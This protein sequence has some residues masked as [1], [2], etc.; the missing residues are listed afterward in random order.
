M[1]Q[2]K[3]F[4]TRY[5][6][7]I[8]INYGPKF[9]IKIFLFIRTFNKFRKTIN[10]KKNF[11]LFSKKNLNDINKFEF[12]ITSQNNEDGIIEYIFSKIP[13][14]KI[15]CEIGFGYYEFNSLNLIQ[16]GWSGKLVDGSKIECLAL[17]SNLSFFFPN[18]E[19]EIFNKK[20]TK[21][22]INSLIFQG[23]KNQIIDFFSIDIDGND[24]WVLKNLDLELINVIC[25]EYNHWFG[26]EKKTMNYIEDF[27]FLD[28]GIFGASLTAITDL[29]NKKDFSLIGVESSGT[30]AFFVKN[31]Y[32]KYFK[33]LTPDESFK[34]VGR[35]YSKEK[36]NLIFRNIKES[37]IL[38]NI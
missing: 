26:M 9:L 20:V 36:K 11:T 6:Q 32:I 5:I 18:A 34:S 23:I 27:N 2:S 28:D 15:F 25:C 38:E 37:N 13:N 31:K 30:N 22:N 24:Y 16:K 33:T 29:L 1:K 7:K 35:F 4:L 10:K 8:L 14:N 19:V 12:K 3:F 17:E 21:E